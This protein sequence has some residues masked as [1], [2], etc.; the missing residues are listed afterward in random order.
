MDTQHWGRRFHCNDYVI[1][2]KS[3]NLCAEFVGL[4]REGIPP[5]P[6]IWTK[7]QVVDGLWEEKERRLEE[8]KRQMTTDTFFCA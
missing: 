4:R 8:M 6:A 3:C 5:L 2:Y 1:A 7:E